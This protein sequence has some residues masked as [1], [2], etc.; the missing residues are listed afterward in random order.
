VAPPSE[1]CTL[2]GA[3]RLALGVCLCYA[4]CLQ[5]AQVQFWHAQFAHVSVQDSQEQV[6]WLQVAQVQVAQSHLAHTS[7][8]SAHWHVVHSS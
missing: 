7:L 1:P 5:V 8:Q 2:L 4:A 6:L 3:V